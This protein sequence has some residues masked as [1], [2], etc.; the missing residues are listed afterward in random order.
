MGILK[1]AAH[2]LRRAFR[3]GGLANLGDKFRGSILN[4]GSYT[5]DMARGLGLNTRRQGRVIGRKQIGTAERTIGDPNEPT[6]IN[7][8]IM[9][10]E[11]GPRR[12]NAAGY[13][14]QGVGY[15]GAG[16]LGAKMIAG[17][18]PTKDKHGVETGM[19]N[20]DLIKAREKYQ[21]KIGGAKKF[22]PALLEHASKDS[23]WVK[24][25]IKSMGMDKYK[26]LRARVAG[27]KAGG[28]AAGVLHAALV[29]ELAKVGDEEMMKQAATQ[30]YV[31]P[32]LA[33]VG[34]DARRVIV[35]T[36]QKG[37]DKKSSQMALQYEFDEG[38][39]Q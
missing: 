25:A 1:S 27:D 9:G 18:E 3:K 10:N 22:T 30:D 29:D 32:G 14:A 17:T 2:G 37:K 31:L 35:I 34:D 26:K 4:P 19:K 15:A 5:E 36:N 12:L 13:A 16:T 33:K 23:Q 7:E 8:A 38:D 11:Y 24:S 21:Q 6:V 28:N 20:E 39:D